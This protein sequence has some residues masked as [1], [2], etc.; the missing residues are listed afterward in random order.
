MAAGL[1]W[2][3]SHHVGVQGAVAACF[4]SSANSWSVQDWRG[5][6]RDA[7]PGE[8]YYTEVNPGL[9]TGR[10]GLFYMIF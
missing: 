4:S 1:E 2:L 5:Y 3:F 9:L 6:N 7:L 8:L 10:L